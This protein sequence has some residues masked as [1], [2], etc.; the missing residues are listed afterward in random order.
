[1]KGI[2]SSLIFISILLSFSQSVHA[3]GEAGKFGFG[4][5][6]ITGTGNQSTVLTGRYWMMSAVALNAGF[7]LKTDGR[8]ALVLTGGF[9]KTILEGESVYPYIGGKVTITAQEAP[10]GDM[11]SFAGSFGAEFF[12]VNRFS[13]SGESQFV[14]E[15]DNETSVRTQATLSVL[16]Y[17][18]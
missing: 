16:F 4:V 9:L 10:L 15:I 18:N 13:I 6:D 1:M 8:N 17:L 3:Q 7:G 5:S 12:V 14:V 2:V 11:V